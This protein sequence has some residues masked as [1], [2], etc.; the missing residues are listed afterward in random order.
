MSICLGRPF[1]ARDE[2]CRCILP[3]N[4][5]DEEA[6]AFLTAAPSPRIFQSVEH[7]PLTGFLAFA[8]LCCIAGKCESLNSPLGSRTVVSSDPVRVRRYI[9]KARRC[10][11]I[12]EEWLGSLPDEF[13]FSANVVDSDYTQSPGLTMCVIAFIMHAGLLLNMYRY[14]ATQTIDWESC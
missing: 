14:V 8:R 5:R 7:L 6:L 2:D 1:A 9:T 12:L 11:K 10:E 4:V 13:T 3:V